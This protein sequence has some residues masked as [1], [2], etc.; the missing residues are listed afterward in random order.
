MLMM[1]DPNVHFH[2]IPRYEGTRAWAGLDFP[3]AGWPGPPRRDAATV[4]DPAIQR[5]MKDEVALNFR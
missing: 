4:L 5:K 3:D 2:V 1:V